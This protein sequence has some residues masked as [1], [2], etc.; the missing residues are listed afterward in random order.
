MASPFDRGFTCVSYISDKL[1][2]NGPGIML[3]LGHVIPP[4]PEFPPPPAPISP[5]A[6]NST[7]YLQPDTGADDG[8]CSYASCPIDVP[9]S[10]ASTTISPIP[11]Y[12]WSAKHN[13]LVPVPGSIKTLCGLSMFS[14]YLTRLNIKIPNDLNRCQ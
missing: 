7:Y 4:P 10:N 11:G 14:V 2:K 1:D 6:S 3:N 12:L 13:S 9:I 5:T 8:T